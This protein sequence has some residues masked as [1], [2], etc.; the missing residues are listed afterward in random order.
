MNFTNTDCV[1]KEVKFYDHKQMYQQVYWRVIDQIYKLS[2][3]VH[4]QTT[5]IRNKI[6]RE[7]T[8]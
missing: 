7:I 1:K 4:E 5:P 3:E 8:L 6:R 2:V